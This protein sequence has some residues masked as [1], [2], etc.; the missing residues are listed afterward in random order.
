MAEISIA[1]NSDKAFK[2]I[3][4]AAKDDRQRAIET[5][6]KMKE[7]IEKVDKITP[8]MLEALNGSQQLIQSSTDKLVNLANILNKK[9]TID[10]ATDMN[11]S[12][13][14]DLLKDRDSDEVIKTT[15]AIG[16]GK[17]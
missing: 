17:K 3:Y 5:F 13:D 2:E 4:N 15:K 14:K 12:F 6:E 8:G 9:E 7:M 11:F 1:I 16:S 10:K